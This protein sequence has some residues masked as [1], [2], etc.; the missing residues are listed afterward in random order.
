[1]LITVVD[2]YQKLLNTNG[3]NFSF[4]Y[5]KQVLH[6]VVQFLAG[7]PLAGLIVKEVQSGILVK[8]DPV[9]LPTILP[10]ELRRRLEKAKANLISSKLEVI[11]IL[12]VL[13]I[14][15]VLKTKPTANLSSITE[16]FS[17]YS[18]TLQSDML[19]NSLSSLSEASGKKA[20]PLKV[21]SP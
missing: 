2:R 9:G 10:L 5:T 16:P 12:S 6:L 19:I 17:G 4:T 14:F 8:V 13:S 3:N 20:L 15:R 11:T 18:R 1:M 21:K 7:G